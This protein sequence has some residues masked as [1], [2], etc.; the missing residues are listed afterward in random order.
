[1]REL[2]DNAAKRPWPEFS[3]DAVAEW[4]IKSKSHIQGA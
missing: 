3:K 1:V 2:V 4:L